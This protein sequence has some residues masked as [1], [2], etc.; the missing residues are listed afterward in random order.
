MSK[1]KTPPEDELNIVDL[2]SDEKTEVKADPLKADPDIIKFL[3]VLQEAFPE[4]DLLDTV[5]AYKMAKDTGT[6][7]SI[8]SQLG[9]VHLD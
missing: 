7:E 8:L 5:K 3:Q 4:G 1:D 9:V 6:M 2:S